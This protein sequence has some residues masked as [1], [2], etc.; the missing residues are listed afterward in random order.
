MNT[1]AGNKIVI[2]GCGNVA[3]HIAKRL[4]A[5]GRFNLLVYNH[6]A[7]PALNEFNAFPGC[8][9][10]AGLEA[11]IPDADVYFV[12]VSDKYISSASA[13]IRCKEGAAALVVH[14]SGS[15]EL[16]GIKSEGAAR[17]VFYPLQ[18]F[19]KKDRLSWNS[20]PIILEGDSSQTNKR[21]LSLA[22]IFSKK[23]QL[24]NYQER[25]RL[26]LAA[27][28]VNNFTNALYVA[29]SEIIPITEDAANFDLL[30][31]LIKQTT[32]KVEHIKPREAQTG[33]AR[34]GDKGVM[35]KHLQLL[36]S[37]PALQEVYKELSQLI[38]SQQE[39]THA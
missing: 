33:P 31:P 6:Q 13:Y 28:L 4:S 39:H 5:D 27:V 19:S 24:M 36:Y 12:C 30:L 17:G 11:I 26:H 35:D 8:K 3:W 20:I 21:L 15:A 10:I 32:R 16:S 29:A 38:N 18:T 14:T 2:L 23:A 25:L 34:R 22:R 9:T 1:F 7:S 37:Q